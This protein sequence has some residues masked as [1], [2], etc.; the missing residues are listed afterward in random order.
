MSEKVQQTTYIST[1]VYA[2]Y[3][4]TFAGKHYL[5]ALAGYNYE[6][7]GSQS[8]LFGAKWPVNA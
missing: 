2:E 3:E 5:K 4:N 1:N 8:N 7:T 6:Q